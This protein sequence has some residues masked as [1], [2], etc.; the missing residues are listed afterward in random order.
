MSTTTFYNVWRTKS[1]ADRAKLI[2]EMRTEAPVLASKPG[3]EALVASECAEDGRVLVEGRWASKAAFEA[4]VANNAD[5][6]ASR[7]KLE[8]YGH[9]EPGLFVEAFRVGPM[10]VAKR[11]PDSDAFWARFQRK[12]VQ[13]NGLRLSVVTGGKGD[14]VL[15]VP[16]FLETWG[17]WSRVMPLLADRYHVIAPDLRGFGDSEGIGRKGYDKK[18]LAEDMGALADALGLERFHVVGHDFGG[19][20]AYR[21]AAARRRQVA[22]LTVIE[23]LLPGISVPSRG[24][25]GRWWFLPFHMAPEVPEMLTQGRER[26]YV[27]ALWKTFVEPHSEATADDQAEVERAFSRPGALA[28]GFELYRTIPADLADF[29]QTYMEKLGIPVL[30]LGGEHCFERRVLETFQQVA[31]R[32]EGGVVQGATHYTPLERSRATAEPILSFLAAS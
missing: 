18:T 32:V 17:V 19:Q 7:S 26:E 25:E 29:K 11:Y 23:A 21:L 12:T 10:P 2:V 15:L 3:F 20:V 6:Q 31:T 30:A 24:D 9:A 5:A 14:P 4:A 27:A 16:G 13:A 1:A 22:T 8:A 28:A